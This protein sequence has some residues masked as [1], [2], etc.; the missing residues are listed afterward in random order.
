MRFMASSFSSLVD[1]LTEE[2]N[3]IKCK[4]CGCF[5]DYESVKD[6]SMKYKCLSCNK[7]YSNKL[8]KELKK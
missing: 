8:D 4:G 5:L 1:N 7:N 3:K 2:I 6:N